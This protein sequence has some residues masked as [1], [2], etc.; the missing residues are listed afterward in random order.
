VSPLDIA[1]QRI[2]VDRERGRRSFQAFARMAWSEIDPAPLIW[3]WHMGAV[4]EQLQAVSEGEIKD[5]VICIPPGCSKSKIASALWPAWDWISRPWRGFLGAAYAQELAEKEAKIHRDLVCSTWYRERWGDR[6]GIGKEQSKRVRAFRNDRL[7][8]RFTTSVQGQ[9]TGW[10]GDIRIADDLNKAQDAQGKA[11]VTG[12]ALKKASDFYWKVYGTRRKDA[13]TFASVIIGQ[14]LHDEDVPGQAIARG[15]TALILPMEYD[16]KRSCVTVRARV[17]KATATFRTVTWKDPR[18]TKGELLAPERFPMA[19]VEKDKLDP[20][21]FA[22]QQ[23]Q[24]P[25]PEF[26]LLFE[27]LGAK[28]Y[29]ARPACTRMILTCD[30]AF[31]DKKT[32]DPVSC[33]VWGYAHPHFYLLDNVTERLNFGATCDTIRALLARWPGIVGTYVE[34]KANGP[35]IM[36]TLLSEVPGLIAWQP[37]SDSKYSRA[38]AMAPLVKAGNVWIPADGAAPWVVDYLKELRRFPMA[39]HDDQVDATVMALRILHD[40]ISTHYAAAWG[41]VRRELGRR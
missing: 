31:K 10:H 7:G 39:K 25:V 34:D 29:D 30:A 21:T 15:Y 22:A 20:I 2:D 35:A 11:A 5:L 24:D 14:R 8:F 26:G 4:C 9:A 37:G 40:P 6:V 1:R 41:K 38:E 18:T 23:Q 27:T 28:R 16:P 3:G 33:Q 19:V 12:E 32:S 13:A 17:D 36:E